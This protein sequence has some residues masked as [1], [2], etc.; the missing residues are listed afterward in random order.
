[1][2][3]VFVW[4]LIILKWLDIFDVNKV[5]VWDFIVFKLNRMNMLH[6]PLYHVL[7][8]WQC[9]I[10]MRPYFAMHIG[11]VHI[12]PQQ[13]RIQ[14]FPNGD[15]STPEGV[16]PTHYSDA[17]SQKLHENEDHWAKKGGTYPK[18]YY[19]DPPL[20]RVVQYIT[21][22]VLGNPGA[23]R[24]GTSVYICIYILRCN[25]LIYHH[26]PVHMKGC[27]NRIPICVRP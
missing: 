18:C 2:F 7:L 12:C 10:L 6:L 13:L 14:D 4:I 9:N 17:F 21:K 11:G 20:T 3:K 16:A 19:V 22:H 23:Y 25:I 26:F 8:L 24:N 5:T 15:V 1:M 27:T